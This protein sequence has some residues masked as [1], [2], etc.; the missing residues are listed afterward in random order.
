MP[1]RKA[2]IVQWVVVLLAGLAAFFFSGKLA[3]LSV[4]LG[5]II[6]WLPNV[7]FAAATIG[8]KVGSAVMLPVPMKADRLL[9]GELMK[10]ALTAILF[11][12]V[13]L[14]VKPLMVALLFA[15]FIGAQL[16]YVVA[17]ALLSNSGS[18]H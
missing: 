6:S 1:V 10:W 16:A 12:V 14:A 9:R 4:I 11:T 13:F 2:L 18:T 8:R 17:L 7:A 3:A 15:G 5:G